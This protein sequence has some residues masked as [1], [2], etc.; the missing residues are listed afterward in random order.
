MASQRDHSFRKKHYIALFS[1]VCTWLAFIAGVIVAK[2][3]KL[4]E[5]SDSVTT[6]LLV[7]STATV[8]GIFVIAAKWLYPRK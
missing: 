4:I 8:L 6:A 3:L 2:G 1:L 7:N 5:L